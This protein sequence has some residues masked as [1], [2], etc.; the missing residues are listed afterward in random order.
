MVNGQLVSRLRAN[1]E[2]S[3]Y[4]ELG[5]EALDG[6]IE[7]EVDHVEESVPPQGSGQAPVQAPKAEAVLPHD[8]LGHTPRAG[9][10][11]AGGRVGLH[12]HLDDLERIHQDTFSDPGA[13]ASQRE[14]LKGPKLLHR[15]N[16]WLFTNSFPQSFVALP[17]TVD[18]KVVIKEYHVEKIFK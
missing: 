14:R 1:S 15:Q 8:G 10:L 17:P 7:A 9:H 16:R 12:G 4:V 13:Q 3:R 2:E 6:M 18:M 11:F 5:Q